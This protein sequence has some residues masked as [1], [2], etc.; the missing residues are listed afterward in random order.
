MINEKELLSLIS[1]NK[2][3]LEEYAE[4]FLFTDDASLRTVYDSMNYSFT[5]GGKRV[6]PFLAIESAKI[7]GGAV[8]IVLPAACAIEMIHTYSLIHDDLPCMDDDD[9]RR[10]KPTN[11]RVY[12][13]AVAVLAGDALLTEAFS[14][15]ADAYG[16]SDSKKVALISLLAGCAGA[17]GMIGGQ[18][19]DLESEGN[20][21]PLETLQKMHSLKTGQLIRASCLIGAICADYGAGT[22]QYAALDTYARKIG[23]VFQIVDDILDTTSTAEVLGKNIGSDRENDKTTYMS[24]Y[25]VSEA[26]DVARCLTN[27]AISVI[28]PYDTNGVL[29]AF[30]SY[31]L[32]REF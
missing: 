2:A 31:L 15:V 16:L 4:K 19:V 22:P 13:E 24:F 9:L 14:T 30:A 6:R 26:L 25:S 18:L 23:M 32:N 7:F 28:S 8:D 11:H 1:A 12:G 10:G 27:E 17:R 21:I 20:R 3:L 5:A 29:S